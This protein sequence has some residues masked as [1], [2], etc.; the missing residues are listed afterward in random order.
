MYDQSDLS[1]VDADTESCD[2]HNHIS[3]ISAELL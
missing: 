1:D 3:I 2:D